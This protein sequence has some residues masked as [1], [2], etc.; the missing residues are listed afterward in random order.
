ML[1]NSKDAYLILLAVLNVSL[2]CGM[3]LIGRNQVEFSLG[4][5]FLLQ[6]LGAV[7]ILYLYLVNYQCI[8]HYHLHKAFFAS[9]AG[10]QIFSLFNTLALGVPQTL[11]RVHHQFHHKGN[12]DRR[13]PATG[14][15]VDFASSYRFSQ[16]P[17]VEEGFW[18]FT[19][20]SVFRAE[21]TPLYKE[22]V[23]QGQRAQIFFEFLVLFSFWALLLCISWKSFFLF[24]L[25][26]WLIGQILNYAE[27]YA[28]HFGV[29]H[30]SNLDNSVSCYNRVYNWL[31]FNNGYHQEHH[32]RPSVHW[33]ELPSVKKLMLDDSRRR[34]VPYCH[35]FNL[36][37]FRA[38]SA[39]EPNQF[40][41]VE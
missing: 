31:W 10:N 28:E 7:V 39:I 33:T 38:K 3:A 22:G 18:S 29:S 15:T 11:Y 6:G 27:N 23:R 14:T 40:I 17:N 8:S 2:I 25:P 5:W 37:F 16:D 1:R 20:K 35:L 34:I 21:I 19:L 13:N 12:N 30:L 4:L 24:Y 36:P 9:A 32:F 41:P 26:L